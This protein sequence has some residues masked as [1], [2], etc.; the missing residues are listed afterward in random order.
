VADIRE[1]MA[2][3]GGNYKQA[4]ALKNQLDAQ[5]EGQGQPAPT[6]FVPKPNYMD[7]FKGAG[8]DLRMG[9]A[10]AQ[11]EKERP[12]E[13]LFLMNPNISEQ[14]KND[15]LFT[16]RAQPGDVKRVPRTP[17]P[18]E[19]PERPVYDRATELA[20]GLRPPTP[21]GG[22]TAPQPTAPQ[23]TAP[24]DPLAGKGPQDFPFELLD[25][26]VGALGGRRRQRPQRRQTYNQMLRGGR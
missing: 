20:E 5:F 6:P 22:P 26:F 17:T 2:V 25:G 12:G 14:E 15:Y 7:Q 4:M 19:G 13:F 21:E 24:V 23:P 11:A 8:G 16:T 18:Y 3:T 10:L 9:L 1:L